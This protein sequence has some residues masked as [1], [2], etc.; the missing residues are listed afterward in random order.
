VSNNVFNFPLSRCKY[1]MNTGNGLYR[2][3]YII[4][5]HDLS[6]ALVMDIKQSN[7]LI[8]FF[9]LLVVLVMNKVN[10]AMECLLRF[11]C[12]TGFY[13]EVFQQILV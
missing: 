13:V 2:Y 6:V 10:H 8:D 7:P 11:V 9:L 4:G 1:S 12:L 5:S 3:R